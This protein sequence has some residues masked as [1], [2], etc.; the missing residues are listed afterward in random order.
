VYSFVDQFERWISPLAGRLATKP[1]AD[2]EVLLRGDHTPVA[3]TPTT[4]AE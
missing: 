1:S 2:D 3:P 4:P